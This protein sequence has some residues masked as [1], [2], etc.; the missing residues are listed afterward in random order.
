MEMI[1]Y[2]HLTITKDGNRTDEGGG[3]TTVNR[4]EIMHDLKGAERN[5]IRSH[6]G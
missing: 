3:N 1:C 5:T 4:T 2:Y 6:S